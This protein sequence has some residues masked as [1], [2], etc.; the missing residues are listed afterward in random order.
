MSILP[1]SNYMSQEPSAS[2][3]P[4]KVITLTKQTVSGTAS[5]FTRRRLQLFCQSTTK[6]ASQTSASGRTTLRLNVSR[7]ILH[8]HP[9]L[10]HP[11]VALRTTLGHSATTTT[12]PSAFI[13]TQGLMNKGLKR[14]VGETRRRGRSVPYGRQR[15]TSSQTMPTLNSPC[16]QAPLRLTLSLHKAKKRVRR[17]SMQTRTR[18][19]R[20]VSTK[21]R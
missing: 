13:P 6:S 14:L 17:R 16:Y 2:S 1:T 4:R 5:F 7:P 11:V 10:A 21:R 19:Q 15:K 12:T 20:R 3:I 18:R 9:L 8:I